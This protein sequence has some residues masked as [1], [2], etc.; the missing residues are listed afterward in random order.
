MYTKY[1]E[2]SIYVVH[3]YVQLYLVQLNIDY[4][5]T[6]VHIWIYTVLL[7]VATGVYVTNSEYNMYNY[8]YTHTGVMQL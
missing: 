4:I 7:Y 2:V 8:T 6:Y 1:V 3:T 5:A